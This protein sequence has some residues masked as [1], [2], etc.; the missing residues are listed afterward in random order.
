MTNQLIPC[1]D[2]LNISVTTRKAILWCDMCN[3]PR[4]HVFVG[5]RSTRIDGKVPLEILFTCECGQCRKWGTI[6]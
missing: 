3:T 1:D 6:G 2:R 5:S 4:P